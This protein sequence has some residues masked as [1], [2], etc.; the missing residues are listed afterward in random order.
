[1]VKMSHGL[2]AKTRGITTKHPRER[3]MSPITRS[4]QTFE[5]GEKAH[6]VIDPAVHRGMPHRRFHGLTGV[7]TGMLGKAYVVDVKVG[8]A[9]KTIIVRRE[10]LRKVKG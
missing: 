1:M 9:K 10:H 2:R 5:V 4:L 3:G 7:V 8:N 6:I